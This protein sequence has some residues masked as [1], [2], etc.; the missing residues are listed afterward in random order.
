MLMADGE[1]IRS[2]AEL[3]D[4]G[5]ILVHPT[6]DELPD[7]PIFNG[8]EEPLVETLLASSSTRQYRAGGLI[9]RQ[10]E[11]APDLHV[12]L[13]GI[14]DLTL[15]SRKSECGV[16]L[17]SSKDLLLPATTLFHEPALVS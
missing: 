8:V 2:G 7:L 16:L 3:V 17:L 12:V 13:R 10:G 4:P 15:L 9:V 1:R 6:R 11:Q 5:S 14:V